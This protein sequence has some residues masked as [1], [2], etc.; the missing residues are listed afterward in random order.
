VIIVRGACAVKS[1][2]RSSPR[3]IDSER[4]N[5]C[6]LCLLVGCPAIRSQPER[7]YIDAS[8]CMGEACAICQQLCP[9]KAIAP[10]ENENKDG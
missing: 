1:P 10:I 7:L 2:R 4:C 6:E 8:L 3:A 5:R 9:Q